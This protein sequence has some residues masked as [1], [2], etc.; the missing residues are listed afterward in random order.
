VLK[1]N[2]TPFFNKKSGV[3]S[4]WWGTVHQKMTIPLCHK[5]EWSWVRIIF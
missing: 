1:A 5:V 2:P 4:F 3:G